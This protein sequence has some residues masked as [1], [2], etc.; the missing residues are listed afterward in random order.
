MLFGRS[1]ELALGRRVLEQAS[2]GRGG[3]LVLSGEPGIGKSALASALRD[4]AETAGARIAFGRAWEVGGAP[5]Y[6]PWTQALADLGIRLE[7]VMGSA[8]GELAAAR[9]LVAFDHITHTI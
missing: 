8:S 2:E 7:E 9:R 5:T 3:T 1:T 6:W 4:V